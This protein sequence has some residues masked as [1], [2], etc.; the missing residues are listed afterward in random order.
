M[1]LQSID[2]FLVFWVLLVFFLRFLL[3]V[4]FHLLS[5][6]GILGKSFHTEEKNAS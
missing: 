6:Y 1:A 4:Q 5:C 3:L 2:L